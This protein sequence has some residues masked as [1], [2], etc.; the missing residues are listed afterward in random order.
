M[1]DNKRCSDN[2]GLLNSCQHKTLCVD[3][4]GCNYIG[5]CDFQRPRKIEIGHSRC[6]ECGA[7]ADAFINNLCH[8]CWSR[9]QEDKQGGS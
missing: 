7:E 8:A 4:F 5:I 6:E 3:Y 9:S 1:N 2:N